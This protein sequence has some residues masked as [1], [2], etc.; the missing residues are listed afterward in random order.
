MDMSSSGVR[1]VVASAPGLA[2]F[3]SGRPPRPDLEL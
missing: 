2:A 3:A 1:M